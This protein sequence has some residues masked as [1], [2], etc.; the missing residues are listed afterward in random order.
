MLINTKAGRF[1]VNE[2]IKILVTKRLTINHFRLSN[3]DFNVELIN[4]HVPNVSKSKFLHILYY[5]ILYPEYYSIV[6]ELCNRNLI[7]IDDVTI[8]PDHIND[9]INYCHPV[10]IKLLY[11]YGFTCDTETLKNKFI[12]AVI[13]Y[14]TM[15]IF[16]DNKIINPVIFFNNIK[17]DDYLNHMIISIL[18]AG[19]IDKQKLIIDQYMIGLALLFKYSREKFNTQHFNKIITCKNTDVVK[20]ILRYIKLHP[21]KFSIVYSNVISDNDLVTEEIKK[22]IQDFIKSNFI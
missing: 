14:E 8:Q 4:L 10:Y 18:A 2:L 19:K 20:R 5:L 22:S 17:F 12:E 9:P 16:I 1:T 13:P 7:R 6:N 3:G 11:E 15:K 21:D